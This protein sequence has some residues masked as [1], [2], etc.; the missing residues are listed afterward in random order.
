MAHGG[1]LIT[2]GRF[3]GGC[4]LDTIKIGNDEIDYGGSC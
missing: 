2:K 3:L 1:R 4:V